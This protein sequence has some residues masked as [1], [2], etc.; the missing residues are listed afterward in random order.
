MTGPRSAAEFLDRLVDPGSFRSW[1]TA[2][3]RTGVTGVYHDQ[4]NRA[5]QRSGAD[6]AVLTGRATIAGHPVAVVA[7]DFGFLGGS[8]GVATAHRIIAAVRRATASQLPLLAAPASGGTRMQEGTPAFVEMIAITRAVEV[9][10]AAG[11]PYLVYLRHPTTG[12]VMASWASRGHLQLAEPGALLGF[13]GPSV[14]QALQEKPFPAGVQ[15]AENLHRHGLI[16]DVV[17]LDDLAAVL[18]ETLTILRPDRPAVSRPAPWSAEP[19]DDL[20]GWQCVQS[21]RRADRPGVRDLLRH[22]A[23]HLVWLHGRHLDPVPPLQRGKPGPDALVIVLAD[24]SGQ[25]CLL[26]GQDRAAAAA[27]APLGARQLRHVRHA[28]RIAEQLRLPVV[29]VIDTPGADLS[30]AAE[31]DGLA[32]QIAG[33]IAD[34]TALQVPSVAVLLGQGTGGAAL[35]LFAADRVVAAEHAWLA[36]LTPEGA[37]ALTT[38]TVD[39]A[40]DLARSQ[41]IRARDLYTAGAVHAI[42]TEH[43]RADADPQRFCRDLITAALGQLDRDHAPS[44]HSAHH[45]NDEGPPACPVNSATTFSRT[46]IPA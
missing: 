42:V 36:P 33:C 44:G 3:D 20:D 27:G 34:L 9:H 6:E 43:P 28:L 25:P 41:Q 40:G 11:L 23:R 32:Q 19:A 18:G 1:D 45:L 15:V 24:L 10:K 13:L 38:G 16:D 22:T 7:S 21:T 14:Y 26:I 31:Q 5:E 12:G 39:H 17:D 46:T 2:P 8:I 37:S 30:V 29:T 35:A 4:L